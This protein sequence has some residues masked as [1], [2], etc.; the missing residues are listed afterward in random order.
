MENN[1]Q[2]ISVSVIIPALN[3]EKYI[4]KLLASL[5]NQSYRQNFEIIVADGNSEDKTREIAA[6]MGAKVII[7]NKRSAAAERQAGVKN[8]SCD[9]LIFLDADVAAD[10][11]FIEQIIKPFADPRVV[12]VGSS[13]RPLERNLLVW[14]SCLFWG[15]LVRLSILFRKPLVCGQG[16]AIRKDVFE[17]VGGFETEQQTAEDT[18]LAI[19]AIKL[20][21]YKYNPRALIY[22][23]TRRIKKMGTLKYLWFHLKNYFKTH[24]LHKSEKDY[25]PVR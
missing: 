8:A 2:K 25:Q 18:L 22:F 1:N 13:L 24:F 4:G 17:K 21:K 7:E 5:K 12:L 16:M 15:I 6:N 20:G 9:I 10:Y 14:F 23:S 11:F 19:K 3:E